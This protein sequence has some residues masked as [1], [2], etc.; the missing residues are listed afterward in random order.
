MFYLPRTGCPP[1]CAPKV[2]IIFGFA[3]HCAD[4]ALLEL[5]EEHEE[6]KAEYCFVEDS[7]K[8]IV[9]AKVQAVEEVSS[10]VTGVQ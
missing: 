2:S 5:R 7:G 10:P 9:D 6:Q 8:T 3:W 1:H 4:G